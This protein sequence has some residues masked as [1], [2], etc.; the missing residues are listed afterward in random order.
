[1]NQCGIGI[2][3]V[4]D[5]THEQPTKAQMDSLILLVETLRN[6]YHIPLSRV[7][8]H[9]DAPGART[10]CPGNS[11]P[12]REFKER[13]RKGEER[14]GCVMNSPRIAFFDTKPYDRKFFEAAD[15]KFGFPITYFEEHLGP[16]T[17]S[18]TRGFNTVCIFVNDVVDADVIK[19]LHKNGIRLIALRASGYNNVDFKAAFGKIMLCAC[20]PIRRMPLQ[21]MPWP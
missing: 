3:L 15:K 19:V 6:Y 14:R 1:M 2:C 9:K 10:E 5:F 13:L 17:A 21:N 8:R 16:G 18:S 7:I 12:W 4:G 20:R 11:F